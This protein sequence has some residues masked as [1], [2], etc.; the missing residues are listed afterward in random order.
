[1]KKTVTTSVD[2]LTQ[3]INDAVDSVMIP[4]LGELTVLGVSNETLSQAMTNLIE[5]KK[6][7]DAE[8]KQ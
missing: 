5:R 8:E 1:M 7:V 2:E 4:L 3:K 6:S